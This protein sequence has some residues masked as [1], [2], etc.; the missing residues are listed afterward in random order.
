MLNADSTTIRKRSDKTFSTIEWST[1]SNSA[2]RSSGLRCFLCAFTVSLARLVDYT[3]G[4][5]VYYRPTD[6]KVRVKESISLLPAVCAMKVK[7]KVNYRDSLPI[8]LS[9]SL[10][11]V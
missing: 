1:V 7:V 10:I 2:L 3:A 5:C 11:T 6:R 4:K 9:I 8:E